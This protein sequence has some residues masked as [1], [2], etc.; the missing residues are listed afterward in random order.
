[1]SYHP[2][3]AKCSFSFQSVKVMPEQR[4]ESDG[5]SEILEMLELDGV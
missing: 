5:V 1:M 3:Q 4:L 2:T